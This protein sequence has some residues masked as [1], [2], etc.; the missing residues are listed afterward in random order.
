[1]SN[2]F[3]TG[4]R[5]TIDGTFEVQKDG[6]GCPKTNLS[7]PEWGSPDRA[8]EVGTGRAFDR[9]EDGSW[10]LSKYQPA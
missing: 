4:N 1:M 6:C 3:E 8:F 5:D 10:E 2:W 7:D 9:A